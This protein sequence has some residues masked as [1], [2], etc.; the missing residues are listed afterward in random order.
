[1]LVGAMQDFEPF[2]TLGNMGGPTGENMLA[3]APATIGKGEN[4]PPCPPARLPFHELNIP[5]V[6]NPL[7]QKTRSSESSSGS[8][9]SPSYQSPSTASEDDWELGDNLTITTFK[10]DENMV[11]RDRGEDA[12]PAFAFEWLSTERNTEDELTSNRKRSDMLLASR[13]IQAVPVQTSKENIPPVCGDKN[14]T[15]SST[16]EKLGQ[17]GTVQKRKVPPTRQRR[18]TEK[19]KTTKKK[20]T[21]P[22]GTQYQE[23]LGDVAGG[24]GMEADD[25]QPK[26]KEPV[27]DSGKKMCAIHALGLQSFIQ[28]AKHDCTSYTKP[29]T[30]FDGVKC[31]GSC[32]Q[33]LNE[34]RGKKGFSSCWYCK[35]G[36]ASYKLDEDISEMCRCWICIPCKITM[37]ENMVEGGRLR[38]AARNITAV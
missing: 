29:G 8:S 25:L 15:S 7:S 9:S 14:A 21:A 16:A 35:P 20:K 36:F 3:L 30:Y 26:G 19:K 32:G 38:R 31:L 6:M 22:T 13:L 1:M 2:H 11:T 34:L 4:I 18:P 24:E 37:E 33:S 10:Q 27:A 23:N 28:M 5:R 17:V 12:R